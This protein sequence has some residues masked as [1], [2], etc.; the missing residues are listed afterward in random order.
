MKKILLIDPNL[1]FSKR[2]QYSLN[3]ILFPFATIILY[4]FD[5]KIPYEQNL[6]NFNSN[7]ISD[8]DLMIIHESFLKEDQDFSLKQKHLVLKESKQKSNFI[9]TRGNS[10][11]VWKTII[12]MEFTNEEQYQFTD[13]NSTILL[14]VFDQNFRLEYF[15]TLLKQFQAQ[16]KKIFILPLKPLYAWHYNA[17]FHQGK[18]LSDLILQIE[19]SIPLDYQDIGHIFEKQKEHYFLPRPSKGFEDI[20]YCD[21]LHLIE[22]TKLFQKF[23]QNNAE[24]SIGI[25]DIENLNF[26]IVKNI[27]FHLNQVHFDVPE[28]NYFGSEKAKELLAE[29]LAEK[30]NSCVFSPLKK[31][32]EEIQHVKS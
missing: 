27:A 3:P 10:I 21:N 12:M 13:S 32:N 22:L 4:S 30:P 5:E 15:Y 17:E 24:D 23:I 26:E 18:T 1:N 7:N 8:I 31:Q 9:L 19:E 20:L 14:Y 29:F 11:Q 16:G 28:N 25:I 6:L 2:I